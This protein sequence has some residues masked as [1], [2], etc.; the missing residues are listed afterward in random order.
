MFSKTLAIIGTNSTTISEKLFTKENVSNI[1]FSTGGYGYSTIN[2]Y[3]RATVEFKKGDTS[4]SKSFKVEGLENF[5]VIV[6][7]VEDFIKTL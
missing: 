5:H 3:W 6:K 7:Q 4:G 1:L 2:P